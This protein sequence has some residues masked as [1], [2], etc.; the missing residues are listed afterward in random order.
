MKTYSEVAV[1]VKSKNIAIPVTGRG[2]SYGSETSK[3][4]HFPDNRLTD[5][6]EA[7]SLKRRPPFTLMKIPVFISVRDGVNPRAILLLERLVQLKNPM[8]SSGIVPAAFRLEV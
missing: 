8:I 4:P 1:Q 6:G 7:V 3:L 5:G 2:G